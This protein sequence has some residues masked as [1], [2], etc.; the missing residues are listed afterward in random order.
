MKFVASILAH[1]KP[2]I[3]RDQIAN[4]REYLPDAA[5]VLHLHVDFDWGGSPEDFSAIPNVLVNPNSLP[6]FW[7]NLHHAHNANF[8]FAASQMDFSHFLLH[9]SSD[10][11]VRQGA[12]DYIETQDAGVSFVA[13]QPEWGAPMF[14]EGDPVFQRIMSDAGA[15]ELWCS[16]VEGTFYRREIFAEMV[17]II[18]RHFD[19]R[20]TLP[21]VHEEIYYPTIASGLGV[22]CGT[23]YLLREDKTNLPALDSNLVDHIRS[24]MLEDHVISRWKLGRQVD[25][26]VWRGHNVYAMRPVPRVLNHPVRSYIRSLSEAA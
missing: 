23:P 13:Q 1:E 15:G 18:E 17:G 24:G 2:E 10:L 21:Y 19:F 7:G 14:A 4:F 9:S 20:K 8:H 16:Q 6:T 26:T 5:I 11:F 3:V 25:A 12:G 22:G